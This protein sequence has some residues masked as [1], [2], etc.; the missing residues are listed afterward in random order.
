MRSASQDAARLDSDLPLHSDQFE[1]GSSSAASTPSKLHRYRELKLADRLE[2]VMEATVRDGRQ[3]GTLKR[4]RTSRSPSPIQACSEVWQEPAERHQRK[5]LKIDGSGHEG[6]DKLQEKA[7][8][9]KALLNPPIECN[10]HGHHSP[11]VNAYQTPETAMEVEYELE[12]GELDPEPLKKSKRTRK[13]KPRQ[14]GGVVT[15]KNATNTSKSSAS[16]VSRPRS[17]EELDGAKPAV[18]SSERKALAKEDRTA[19]AE[20]EGEMMALRWKM[21]EVRA[22]IAVHEA[23]AADYER[24]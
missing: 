20:L 19:A 15:S 18:T 3:R 23:K 13:R 2:R 16:T 6:D 22:R 12:E 1:R 9:D 7:D 24:Q 8:I 5:K 14:K 21:N 4:S 17:L 11:L 10:T